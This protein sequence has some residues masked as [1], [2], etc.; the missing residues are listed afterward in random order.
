MPNAKK[1]SRPAPAASDPKQSVPFFA[2]NTNR[3]PLTVRTDV[4][5]GAMVEEAAKRGQ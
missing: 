2:R 5:A 1:S 4:R 3:A